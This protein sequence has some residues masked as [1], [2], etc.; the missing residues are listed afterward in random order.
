MSGGMQAVITAYTSR[1]LADVWQQLS[2]PLTE[3]P[4]STCMSTSTM[5]SAARTWRTCP[6]LPIDDD[7]SGWTSSGLSSS[8]AGCG[9]EQASLLPGSTDRRPK[10]YRRLV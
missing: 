8:T 1:R 4:A 10:R 9:S 3:P 7:V 2:V 6:P 5:V